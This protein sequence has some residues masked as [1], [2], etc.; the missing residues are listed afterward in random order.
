MTFTSFGY[1][2]FLLILMGIYWAVPKTNQRLWVLLLA[3]FV[4]YGLVS[5]G[6]LPHDR[7][8]AIAALR[9]VA[10]LP[11]LVIST[12]INFRLGMI[13][14]EN[15]PLR[16]QA[17]N[18]NLTEAEWEYA[19]ADWNQKRLQVLGLGIGLNL[20]LLAGFKY[21][22]FFLSSLALLFRLPDLQVTADQLRDN[23]IAPLGIS[24]FTFECIAYLVDI[25]RGAPAT[26]NLLRFVTYKFFFPKLISGPI[27]GY[28]TLARQ[29]RNVTFPT[30][31]RCTEALWLI[32]LGAFKKAVLADHLGILVGLS[33]GNLL[34]AG[35]GDIWLAT[36]AYGLQ[37][38]LDFSAY[39][40]M[41][42]GSA[43]LLGLN[44]PE[45]FDAP[46]FSTSLAD[47]WRRWH[48]TLGNWLR[49]YLYFPLGG[50]RQGLARTCW[51]LTLVMVI[52]GLWHGANWGFIVWGLLHGLGLAIHRLGQTLGHQW[53]VLKTWWRSLPG[54]IV[55]WA[56]TQG[57]VFGSWIFFRLPNLRESWW[58]VTHLWGHGAD[59]QFAQKVYL[60]VS[61]LDRW[62]LT[63]LV[64]AL[65]V[66]MAIVQALRRVSRL[67]FNWPVK[68]LCVPLFFYAVL[69]LA[70]QGALPYIYFDF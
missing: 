3:S 31:N 2:L 40:D 14:G 12:L 56:M 59:A 6:A 25:Y 70:P 5:Y 52:A 42:R 7:L 29:L 13:L 15:S 21:I 23:L 46:Y 63:L 54:T 38:Y 53:P 22:P 64:L 58:A 11:L 65:I 67:Q 20:L 62:Q 47:F 48:M 9:G 57:L 10:Y 37:L 36:I 35:S 4:F 1:A 27:T 55:A 51:N 41:A 32:G 61:G 17:Q 34:R 45:N 18:P 16:A 19:Q 43:L 28:H 8:G 44:L 39:V 50:S 26:P 69:Q 24:F 68:L 49:N 66:A 30:F 33:Y 60:D